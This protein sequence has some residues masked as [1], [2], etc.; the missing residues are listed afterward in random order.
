[1]KQ[2]ILT[3]IKD[4]DDDV[5]VHRMDITRLAQQQGLLDK[6]LNIY[7]ASKQLD[8]LMTKLMEDEEIVLAAGCI[9][10]FHYGKCELHDSYDG[11]ATPAC[12]GG[13][14]CTKC[15]S[16]FNAYWGINNG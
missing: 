15:W 13:R 7:Q 9:N 12:Y 6:S 5:G 3:I 4:L 10:T 16:K 14:G 8:D 2:A 11:R 1:M